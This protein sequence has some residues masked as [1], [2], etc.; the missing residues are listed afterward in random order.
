MVTK[1]CSTS[2]VIREVQIK[3]T[4][5]YH[6]TL[7]CGSHAVLVRNMIRFSHHCLSKLN[8]QLQY[9]PAFTLLGTKRNVPREMNAYVYQKFYARICIADLLNRK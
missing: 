7:V 8:I 5:R 9:G 3:I 4:I 2:L 6:Y 1:L